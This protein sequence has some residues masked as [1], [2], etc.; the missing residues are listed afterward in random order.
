MSTTFFAQQV[1]NKKKYSCV[2]EEAFL[3]FRK[4]H[5]YWNFSWNNWTDASF[6]TRT[7]Y[8]LFVRSFCFTRRSLI[9]WY[10][11]CVVKPFIQATWYFL[12]VM[13]WPN[14]DMWPS[15]SFSVNNFFID[16]TRR[17]GWKANRKKLLGDRL[18]YMFSMY[19]LALL[20]CISVAD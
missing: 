13:T 2:Y 10:C 17:E 1:T 3:R 8:F 16:P 20:L 18:S 14:I 12:F 15:S 11:A 19:S 9:L 5:L 6:E 7:S 4:M